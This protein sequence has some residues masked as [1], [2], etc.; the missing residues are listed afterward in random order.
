F[1][2]WSLPRLAIAHFKPEPYLL[3]AL[4]LN[5][6]IFAAIKT[7]VIWVIV[8]ANNPGATGAARTNAHASAS[9][10]DFF[11]WSP[12]LKYF[13][14]QT[15]FIKMIVCERQERIARRIAAKGKGASG[16]SRLRALER[17]ALWPWYK[18]GILQLPSR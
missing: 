7:W 4:P 16:K 17:M 13:S 14:S 2:A 10:L 11:W 5:D 8:C 3:A 9:S 1:C 6:F 15:Y 18:A 12:L